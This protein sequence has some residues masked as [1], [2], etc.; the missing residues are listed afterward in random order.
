MS[1]VGKERVPSFTENSGNLYSTRPDAG[2]RVGSTYSSRSSSTSNKS[3]SSVGSKSRSTTKTHQSSV[4]SEKTEA[5]SQHNVG[6]SS[7]D[8]L[9]I[10]RR[11]VLLDVNY[12]I[13]EYCYGGELHSK[14]EIFC[15]PTFNGSENL[16]HKTLLI[17]SVGGIQ[18]INHETGPRGLVK[19]YY[20]QIRMPASYSSIRKVS[21][22]VLFNFKT[23]AFED[24]T[25]RFVVFRG[26]RE[27]LIKIIF[28]FYT[29]LLGLAQ[30]VP[31]QNI[32]ATV[33]WLCQKFNVKNDSHYGLIEMATVLNA[34][35]LLSVLL[36]KEQHP[37]NKI[38][39]LL[40]E[41]VRP[42]LFS[43]PVPFCIVPTL[44][45]KED[46]IIPG[47]FLKVL[48]KR[49]LSKSVVVVDPHRSG[50]QIDFMSFGSFKETRKW[51]PRLMFRDKVSK[52]DE[53]D[54]SK[55]EGSLMYMHK[56][57]YIQLKHLYQFHR[58][59]SI[60]LF[61]NICPAVLHTM[62]GYYTQ[63]I[64][65]EAPLTSSMYPK[66]LESSIQILSQEDMMYIRNE[67]LTASMI[68]GAIGFQAVVKETF[69]DN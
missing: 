50:K 59:P 21:P 12:N 14:I 5:S 4:A 36:T 31:G 26:Y 40:I 13:G 3:K 24:K 19:P 51:P 34:S 32:F 48:S 56:A 25:P 27:D 18:T 65:D 61:L 30:R 7:Q 16:P 64:G 1:R 46:F 39:R 23:I 47:D 66:N 10:L 58:D 68:L 37:E 52:T 55:K 22:I 44:E 29:E 17:D 57:V 41:D 2:S 45:K 20:D 67:C 43:K 42:A 33:D 60:V 35:V 28:D 49:D 54:K 6:D 38:P 15:T 62:L 53:N 69:I 9:N 8:R 11:S 63:L